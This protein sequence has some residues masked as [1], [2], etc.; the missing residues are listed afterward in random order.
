MTNVPDAVPRQA[1]GDASQSPPNAPASRPAGASQPTRK[2]AGPLKRYGKALIWGVVALALAC[3]GYY[4]WLKLR[5]PGLP[6]GFAS[7][8]GRIEGT[9]IDVDAKIPGRIARILVDEGD[10]VGVGQVLVHMDTKTLDAQRREA[11]AQLERASIGVETAEA[12]VRQRE[13]E[14]TAATAQIGTRKALWDAAAARLAR[15][16]PMA[17]RD[18]ETKQSL[19]D[20]RAAEH[21]T[22]SAIAEAQ[23]NLAAAEA[24]I[25]RRG[26]GSSTP[27]RPSSPRKRPSTAS[28]P[29]STIRASR[30]H[31]TAGC[32]T[33]S[34]RK[35]RC[36]RRAAGCSI[37]WTSATST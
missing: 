18:F 17:A 6:E 4:A 27:R 1:A 25:S 20:A 33:R 19:D 22:N 32:S 37:S 23:S 7:G 31:A 29:T 36:C 16:E 8:N 24:A 30:R 2:P 34:L 35:A 11:E 15:V 9:E 26:R 3:G 12:V 14:R 5:P 10:F 13:A 21:A 28:S